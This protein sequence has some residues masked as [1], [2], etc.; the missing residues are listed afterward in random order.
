M[1]PGRST[2]SLAGART[3]DYSHLGASGF[4]VGL[5]AVI[6]VQRHDFGM[7]DTELYRHLLGL[8]APWWR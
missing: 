4:S 5:L 8:V 6:R 3:V 1:Q 2:E 7:R